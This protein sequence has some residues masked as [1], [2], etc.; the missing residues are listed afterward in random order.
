MSSLDDLRHVIRGQSRRQEDVSEDLAK[1]TELDKKLNE[2]MAEMSG[3][4][5][6]YPA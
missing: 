2:V 5:A 1:L 4:K 3:K 6:S